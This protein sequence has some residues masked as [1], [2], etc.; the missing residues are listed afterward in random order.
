MQHAVECEDAD[1]DVTVVEDTST[2]VL[3]AITCTSALRERLAARKAPEP[4][5]ERVPGEEG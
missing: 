5:A 4:V 2:H 3:A 1:A